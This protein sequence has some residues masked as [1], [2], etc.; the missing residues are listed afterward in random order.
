MGWSLDQ[1]KLVS[2]PKIGGMLNV[3]FHIDPEPVKKYKNRSGKASRLPLWW[4]W[5][6]LEARSAVDHHFSRFLAKT[7]LQEFNDGEFAVDR[8]EKLKELTEKKIPKTSKIED[9]LFQIFYEYPTVLTKFNQ[10]GGKTL[11]T[12]RVTIDPYSIVSMSTRSP[13]WSSCQNPIRLDTHEQSHKLWAN[14]LDSNMALLEMINPDEDEESSLVARAI[15]RIVRDHKQDLL[16]LDCLYGE[17]GYVTSFV[18]ITREL[19]K[20]IGLV[21]VSGRMLP[22]YTS[23]NTPLN[24]YPTDFK[25]YEPPYLDFGEWKKQNGLYLFSGEGHYIYSL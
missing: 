16:Y 8:L 21:P 19:A 15:L 3:I 7:T 24:G 13:H 12:M 4:Y 5:I 25:H 2:S 18:T 17:R 10:R 23:F 1:R 20:S 22:F 11:Y 14:L 6:S 9:F